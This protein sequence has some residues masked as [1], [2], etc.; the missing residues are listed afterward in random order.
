MRQVLWSFSGERAKVREAFTERVTAYNREIAKERDVW[1]PEELVLPAPVIRVGYMRW[2]GGELVDE[3]HT[4]RSERPE[5]FTMAD[6]LFQ[7][8]SHAAPHLAKD[9]HH[10]FE[11]LSLASRQNPA[12]PPL[13]FMLLGS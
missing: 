7:L 10:F 3:V 8:H 1:R 12:L 6:L 2:R 5:G 4:L 11:G 9:D 13:Y